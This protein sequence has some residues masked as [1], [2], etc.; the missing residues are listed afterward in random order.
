[1]TDATINDVQE[2]LGVTE[3]FGETFRLLRSNL[4]NLAVLVLLPTLMITFV[5]LTLF[6]QRSGAA[7]MDGLMTIADTVLGS[8]IVG[9]VVQLA[10]DAKTDRPVRL[11]NCVSSVASVILPLSICSVIQLL[12]IVIGLFLFLIPGL[13]FMAVYAVVLPSIII[14]RAGF[15]SFTR[16][17]NLTRYYAVPVFGA[18]VAVWGI[19]IA[20]NMAPW[21][22][23]FILPTGFRVAAFLAL[24]AVTNAIAQAISGIFVTLLYLRLRKI[25]EGIVAERTA[26]VFS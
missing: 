7:G 23:S 24:S 13:F 15:S 1:M 25:K 4:F 2:P 8:I 22:L 19:S 9:L 12:A 10:F 16:S 17:M 26:E 20:L 6:S 11:T 18:V 14:E 21:G 5:G 3:L